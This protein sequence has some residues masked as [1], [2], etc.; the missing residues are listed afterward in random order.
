MRPFTLAVLALLLVPTYAGAHGRGPFAWTRTGWV[1][2]ERRGNAEVFLGIPFAAPPV[3][4]LRWRP[5]VPVERW[6]GVR[7]ATALPPECAQLPSTNSLGSATEDCLYLSVYRPAWHGFAALRPLPVLVW[8]HG[9]SALNGSGSQFDGAELATRTG[10]VVVTLNY[11]LGV[12]GYLALPGLTAESADGSSGNLGLLDQQAALRWVHRNVRWLGGDPRRVT[13][14]GQSAGGHSVCVHLA[15]PTA[16]GLFQRAA[17]HSG[18]F[19]LTVSTGVPCDTVP[20]ADAELGGT[21]FAA[22]AGCADPATQLECLRAQS[23]EA[24]LAASTG[25]SSQVPTGGALLPEPVLAAIEAGHWNRVPVLV[26]STHDELQTAAAQVP[27]LGYPLHPVLYQL[28]VGFVFGTNGPAILAEYP[29]ADYPDPAFAFGALLTDAGVACPTQTLRTF[30][31]ERTP[32]FGFEFDDP[33]APPGVQA[34][35]PSGAYH[36]ADVQYLFT[37]SPPQ[38]AFTPEQDALSDQMQRY[39]GAFA[40]RGQPS[41]FGEPPWP[42]FDAAS[43]GVMSLRPG[44]SVLIDDFAADHHCAFWETLAP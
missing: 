23:A 42:R 32:T 34:G 3:G 12:F 25:F 1:E 14:A 39:W 37:Y 41:A 38:G 30:L 22:G 27:I 20:L 29:A 6:R 19:D 17:I 4:E 7:D 5:P 21:A 24:L 16:A 13:I 15:S 31:A 10:T 40:K 18:A 35:M 2:G 44:G 36:T 33:N 9:G 28:A 43:A 8:I 11:R 26:G